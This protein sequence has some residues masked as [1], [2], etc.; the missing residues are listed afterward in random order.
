MEKYLYIVY[1]VSSSE[2]RNSQA[3]SWA[4]YYFNASSFGCSLTVSY[5]GLHWDCLT[6][7]MYFPDLR[8]LGAVFLQV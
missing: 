5:S 4:G 6:V 7:L 1:I 8:D 2:S 3:Y